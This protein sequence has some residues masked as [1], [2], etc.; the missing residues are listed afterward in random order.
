[1]QL[2]NFLKIVNLTIA[3]LQILKYRTLIEQVDLNFENELTLLK[4]ED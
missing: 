2:C 3:S 4:Y 1:M